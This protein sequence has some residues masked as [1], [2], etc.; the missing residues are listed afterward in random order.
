M[1]EFSFAELL[2]VAVVGLVIF[3]PEEMT[4]IA[5][6]AR[7]LFRQARHYTSSVQQQVTA[8]LDDEELARPITIIE[9]DDGNS[10]EAYDISDL[11]AHDSSRA[12]ILAFER[13]P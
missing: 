2:V 7:H 6:Q 5:K 9:G 11:R 4:R 10:Y 1:F 3:G 8:L 12:E 13:K